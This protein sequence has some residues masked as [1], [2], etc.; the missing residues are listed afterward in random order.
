MAKEEVTE[1]EPKKKRGKKAMLIPLIVLVLGMSGGGYFFFAP[2]AEA[3]SPEEIAAE[4]KEA[5]LHPKLGE[6]VKLDPITMNLSDGHVLKVGLAIHFVAEPKDEHIAA[7]LGGGGGHAKP[8]PGASKLAGYESLALNAAIL[9]LGNRTYDE[10]SAVGGKAA[11]KDE[12]AK[13][14]KE[15][16]HGD[17]AEVYYT[18]FVM[19]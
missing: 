3:K 2:K 8:E 6:V 15:L 7:L 4:L 5:E 16:Y 17:A 10:L 18:V 19:S 12:L 13:K 9:D 1:E 11:A 14:I